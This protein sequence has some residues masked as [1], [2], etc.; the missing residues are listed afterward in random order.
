MVGGATATGKTAMSI[1]LAKHYQTEILSADSRQFYKEMSIGTAKPDAEELA[2]APHHFINSKSIEE[3]YSVGDFE[4]DALALLDQ[5]FGSHDLVI[6]TG[7][8]GLFIRAVCEGLDKFP[9]VP[10]ETRA[11]VK[12]LFEEKGLEALQAEV[13]SID[14]DYYAKVDHQ[15]PMRLMR[16]LEVYRASGQP[17]SSFRNQAAQTRPFIPIYI[18]LEMEREQLYERINKRVDL[19]LAAGLEEE[20]RQLLPFKN[21][22]ALQTVGYQE[23]FEYFEGKCSLDDAVAMI[24]QNS[25]RYAKRQGTW[26]RK[27]PHWQSFS[28][29]DFEGIINSIEHQRKK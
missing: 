5:L 12:S 19:M 29:N 7:G 10:Q 14:P 22:N 17:F 4:R 21:Q 1:R 9:E 23:L 3:D 26:F 18:L 27:R 13:A 6:M 24:K 11:A 2:A 25:R 28:P 16:A 20:A 15:N 8:S